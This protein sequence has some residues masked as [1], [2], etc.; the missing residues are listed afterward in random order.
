[1]RTPNEIRMK[2]TMRMIAMAMLRFTILEGGTRE[3]VVD[4][5]EV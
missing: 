3:G 1:M 4:I 5:E 2:R